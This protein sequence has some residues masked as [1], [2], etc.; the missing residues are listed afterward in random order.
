MRSV[1]PL[2]IKVPLICRA[3]QLTGFYMRGILVLKGVISSCRYV[4]FFDFL[5][6]HFQESKK[7][8]AHHNCFLINCDRLV[9]LKG[10]E[11]RT[12]SSQ[13][14]RIFSKN[15]AS[16][17]IYYLA[18]FHDQIIY[19]SKDIFKNVLYFVY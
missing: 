6:E 17:F 14:C 16:D 2:T 13:S 10:P 3:N 5:S 9:N 7:P 19:D 11:S 12:H 1:N 8:Q 15:I 18:K 4:P